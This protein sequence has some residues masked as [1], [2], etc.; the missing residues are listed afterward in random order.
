MVYG[1]TCRNLS[2]GSVNERNIMRNCPSLISSIMTFTESCISKEF[3]DDKVTYL[4][5]SLIQFSLQVSVRRQRNL[6]L[7]LQFV[8][9][10][11]HTTLSVSEKITSLLNVINQ[12]IN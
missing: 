12:S 8:Y 11:H 1:C 6:H 7:H 9:L 2:S 4:N 3:N 5:A 10:F